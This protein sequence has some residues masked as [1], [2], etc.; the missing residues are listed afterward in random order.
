MPEIADALQ[1]VGIEEAFPIQEMT[2]GVALMGTDLI[3]Q[4]RT[5]TGKTL[6]FGIPVIQR[7]VAPARR[8][9]RPGRRRQAAGAHRRPHP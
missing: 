6:A 5:G 4:A 8:R 3:G 2:L 1:A 9:L 7:T